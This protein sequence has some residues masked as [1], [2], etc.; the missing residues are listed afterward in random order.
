MRRFSERAR[1]NERDR[2]AYLRTLAVL[3]EWK[4]DGKSA[5]G[6]LHDAEALAEKIGLPGELWQIRAKIGEI[7][8]RRGAANEAHEAFSR[9]AQTLKTLAQKIA[10]EELKKG[11]LSAPRARRVLWHD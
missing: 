8:E 6:H 10:D 3:S 2:I 4:G 9:A 5:L 11:F 7:C 1:T